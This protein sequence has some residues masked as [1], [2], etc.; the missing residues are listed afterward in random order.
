[1]CG[2][3]VSVIE[4]ASSRSP[5]NVMLEGLRAANAMRGSPHFISLFFCLAERSVLQDQMFKEQ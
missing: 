1:M 2:I 3:V 5:P 4:D